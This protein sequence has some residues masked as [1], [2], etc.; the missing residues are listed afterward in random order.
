MGMVVGPSGHI[1]TGKKQGCAC[2][3][4]KEFA[5]GLVAALF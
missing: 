5:A 3:T 4:A 2:C 1:R